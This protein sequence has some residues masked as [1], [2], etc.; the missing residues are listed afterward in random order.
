MDLLAGAAK[1]DV[2]ERQP[3]VVAEHPVG[4]HSWSTLPICHG[5]AITPQRSITALS[6]KVSRYS[7]M[8]VVDRPHP[9]LPVALG[10]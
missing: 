2:D 1:A 3:E 6:P 5:P 8:E 10:E 9:T 7:S 4:E